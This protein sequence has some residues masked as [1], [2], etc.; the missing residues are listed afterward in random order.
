MFRQFS[1]TCW[2]YWNILVPVFVVLMHGHF[3]IVEICRPLHERYSFD[4]ISADFGL[5]VSL[6]I[7]CFGNVSVIAEKLIAGVSMETTQASKTH[8]VFAM[9]ISFALCVQS[10][11]NWIHWLKSNL[12]YR[13]QSHYPKRLRCDIHIHAARHFE[14]KPIT[15]DAS[16]AGIQS[17]LLV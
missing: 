13:M 6:K 3:L 5:H 9:H 10:S 12:V 8:Y 15:S 7:V 4:A 1:N 14:S 11:R 16:V 17:D 2:I